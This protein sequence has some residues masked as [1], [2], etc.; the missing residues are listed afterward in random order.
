M[1]WV[2][3]HSVVS[4][5]R[6]SEVT[7]KVGIGDVKVALDP[8]SRQQL[9]RFFIE[10]TSRIATRDLAPGDGLL[11]EALT[12]LY[13][14]FERARIDLSASPPRATAPAGTMPPHVYVLDILNEDLRPCLARWH[15]RLE[16]W[17]R[18]GLSEFEWPLRDICRN[19]LELT[20]QRILE[21]AWQLGEAL[22]IPDLVRLLPARPA[23]VPTIA[24]A[25]ELAAVETAAGE[26]RD[27]DSL[28][29]AWRIYVE[30]VTRV[31]IQELPAG[32]GLLGEA[33]ASLYA[34]AGEIRSELKPIPPGRSGGNPESIEGLALALLNEGL[35]PFLSEWHPRY[36]TF[37]A[38]GKPEAEWD[39]AEAC[40]AAL[41]AARQR[42]LPTIRALGQKLRAP[43][44]A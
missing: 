23:V 4:R 32:K 41:A 16:A 8:D 7:L 3:A 15:V 30:V 6:V 28:K 14:L 26:V 12:S 25:E 5:V 36:E 18:T 34:L 31:A 38:L 2:F 9:W 19:D 10:M 11:E 21:R 33:I 29:V 39:Q 22:D 20:G 13:S 17:K 44:L 40:R 37:K 27:A 24:A 35:R 1:A 42:C 43:P